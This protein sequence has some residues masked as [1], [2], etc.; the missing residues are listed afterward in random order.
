[1]RGHTGDDSLMRWWCAIKE[2]RRMPVPPT[3]KKKVVF[4][5]SVRAGNFNED[6]CR[7]FLPQSC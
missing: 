6:C 1:M 5:V 3:K 2:A 7:V 4:V